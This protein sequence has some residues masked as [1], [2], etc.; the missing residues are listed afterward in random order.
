MGAAAEKLDTVVKDLNEILRVREDGS[1]EKE[2]VSL[3]QMT[4]DL[5]TGMSGMIDSTAAIVNADFSAAPEIYTL[6]SAARQIFY[7]L[8]SNSIKYRRAGVAPEIKITSFYNDGWIDLKFKDNGAGIDLEKY[9][10]KLF[11]L[12]ERLNFDTEGRGFGLF[13]TKTLV[14]QLNGKI[15]VESTVDQGS[16][17]VISLPQ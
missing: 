10:D 12:Y 11:V 1:E 3:D 7:Q 6:P 4:L 9:R 13:L 5:L 17:F 2:T 15:K 8:I 16:E 14:E